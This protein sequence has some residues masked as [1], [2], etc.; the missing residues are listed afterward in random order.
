[1]FETLPVELV[2]HILG[3]LDVQHVILA[4][5]LSRRLRDVCA[6][7]VLNPW[8]KPILRAVEE[9]DFAALR[10]LCV[11]SCVPRQT[12]VE[13]LARAPPH[14]IL[15]E[16]TI[17]VLG[18]SDWRES[19]QL[20]F[21][22]SAL[23]K[24]KRPAVPWRE[25]FM[26]A[27]F[28]VQHRLTAVC[29]AYESW[30]K[31]IVIGRRDAANLLEVSSRN[32]N[33]LAIFD[34]IKLQSGMLHLETQVRVVLNLMDVRIVALGVLST[35]GQETMYKNANAHAL[36]HPPGASRTETKETYGRLMQP[37]PRASHGRYPNF[38][39]GGLDRRWQGAGE[40][41]EDGRSWIGGLLLTA[42]LVTPSAETDGDE[43]L[44]IVSGV[45]RSQYASLGWDDLGTLFPWLEIARRID[46]PGL[47][48]DDDD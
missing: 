25:A 11:Y 9:H 10:N 5:T 45:G 34:E 33:P 18:E 28:V 44:G 23:A 31:Y 6:D 2:A 27:M 4:S 8:R 3:D 19:A 22:P 26:R 24:W 15:F 30:T 47:G 7:V 16:V 40:M 21:L 43:G 17:P 12:F 46:G 39:P 36:L 1:M 13:V 48:I 32:F 29:H 37:R 14:A 20:R 35:P 41:E 38:T 42:Q